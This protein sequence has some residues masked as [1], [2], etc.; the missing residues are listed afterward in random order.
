[1][2][3][4]KVSGISKMDKML[5]NSVLGSFIDSSHS[6][7][8]KESITKKGFTRLVQIK[9]ALGMQVI[10]EICLLRQNEFD[11]M[12]EKLFKKFETENCKA[13][14]DEARSKRVLKK[15]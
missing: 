1:M 4:P 8:L 15:Q 14:N 2:R 9:W 3:V 5:L 7:F 12:A 13:K 6:E 11:N 10:P